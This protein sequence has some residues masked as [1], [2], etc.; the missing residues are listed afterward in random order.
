MQP[1]ATAAVLRIGEEPRAAPWRSG[2]AALELGAKGGEGPGAWAASWEPKAAV[3]PG[4]AMGPAPWEPKPGP[5]IGPAPWKPGAAV[6]PGSAMGPTRW[7]PRAGPALWKP[8]AE[9]APGAATGP[10]APPNPGPPWKPWVGGATKRG[11]G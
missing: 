2:A 11:A 3:E 10:G 1:R 4:V 9:G 6:E 8:G 7:K 5:G